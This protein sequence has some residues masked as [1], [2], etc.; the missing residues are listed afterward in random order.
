MSESK[1]MGQF[2][3]K[4]S[5]NFRDAAGPA[6]DSMSASLPAGRGLTRIQPG[7]LNFKPVTVK[8][9]EPGPT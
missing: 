8:M 4:S 6:K 2:E 9:Y 7:R 5:G 3:A 1:K